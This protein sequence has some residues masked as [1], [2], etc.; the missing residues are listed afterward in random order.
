MLARFLDEK[1]NEHLE[2][3]VPVQ[4]SYLTARLREKG[5]LDVSIADAAVRNALSVL[6]VS[7]M[8]VSG[9]GENRLLLGF[10]DRRK[11]RPMSEHTSRKVCSNGTNLSTLI[12][13][14]VHQ[15]GAARL[16]PWEADAEKPA[17]PRPVRSAQRPV[18]SVVCASR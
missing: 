7:P 18:K 8:Y 12:Q 14:G 13:P 10:Q 4:G 16:A 6:P 11:K 2:V 15:A 1:M 3:A 17:G 5:K 9:Q